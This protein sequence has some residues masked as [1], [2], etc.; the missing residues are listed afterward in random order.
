VTVFADDG[1]GIPFAPAAL[2]YG[3]EQLYN[4][5]TV[6]SPG[7]TAVASWGVVA[8]SLWDC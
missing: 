3:T 8:D 2:D 1:T 4:S 5:I 7:S 6:T